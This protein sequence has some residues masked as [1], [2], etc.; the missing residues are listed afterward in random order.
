MAG[1][2]VWAAKVQRM[3]GFWMG[4]SGRGPRACRR[5]FGCGAKSDSASVPEFGAREKDVEGSPREC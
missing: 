5:R 1:V 4:F 3:D 2:A